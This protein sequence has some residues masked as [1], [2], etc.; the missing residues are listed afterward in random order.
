MN[1]STLSPSSPIR[2]RVDILSKRLNEVTQSLLALEEEV[3][4]LQN[5]MGQ[6]ENKRSDHLTDAQRFELGNL[7]A[8]VLKIET[9]L[10]NRASY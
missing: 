7:S 1:T 10:K 4:N 9:F 5:S 8:R 6:Q 3:R 2:E